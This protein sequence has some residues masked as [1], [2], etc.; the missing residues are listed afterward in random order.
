MRSGEE[1]VLKNA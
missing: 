1:H